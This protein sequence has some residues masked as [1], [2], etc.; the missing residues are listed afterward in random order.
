MCN[1]VLSRFLLISALPRYQ[2]IFYHIHDCCSRPYF[3]FLSRRMVK[4]SRMK[5]LSLD[6]QK[7]QWNM[8]PVLVLVVASVKFLCSLSRPKHLNIK[9]VSN[10][11]KTFC[12]IR[13]SLLKGIHIWYCWKDEGSTHHQLYFRLKIV[14]YQILNDIPQ[15]K[16][17]GHSVRITCYHFIQ[18][19][20]LTHDRIDDQ[21]CVASTTNGCS[22]I[23]ECG[24]Q[25]PV[26]NKLFTRHCSKARYW[27]RIGHQGFEHFPCSMYVT[28]QS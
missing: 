14:A 24:T 16:R 12:G 7:I 23:C 18:L 10:G 6:W 8:K 20:I 5:M 21:C 1:R 19:V 13:N 15:A 3:L 2:H 28:S 17:D 22:K 26:S 9:R 25:C 11:F 27:T 4:S